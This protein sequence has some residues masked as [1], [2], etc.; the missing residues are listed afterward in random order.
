MVIISKPQWYYK[1]TSRMLFIANSAKKTAS[2]YHKQ[3]TWKA[4]RLT[5]WPT[6]FL[7]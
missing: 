6:I 3:Q 5:M 4:I 2:I 1:M 7:W